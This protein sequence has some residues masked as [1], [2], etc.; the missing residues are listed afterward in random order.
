MRANANLSRIGL[1]AV[2]VG[3]LVDGC[4]GSIVS[5][6]LFTNGTSDF[7]FKHPGSVANASGVDDRATG[8]M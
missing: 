6:S 5:H 3:I 7:D 4:A 2:A 1:L 8:S